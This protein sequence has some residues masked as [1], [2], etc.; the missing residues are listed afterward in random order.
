MAWEISISAEGWTEI[1]EQLEAWDRDALI[2]AIADD[3]FEAVCQQADQHH[4]ERAANAERGRLKQLPHDI[5]VDRAFELI[6]QNGTCDNG[7]WAYWID[8][9]GFHT[10]QLLEA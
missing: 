7:G 2:A 6:E 8:R 10:V 5:L 9:E 3:K 4:A 1:R